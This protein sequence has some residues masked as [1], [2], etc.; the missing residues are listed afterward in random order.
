[1][2][3]YLQIPVVCSREQKVEE[4]QPRADSPDWLQKEMAHTRAGLGSL[5][6]NVVLLPKDQDRSAFY[7]VRPTC[8]SLPAAP[9]H[10]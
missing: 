7:P 6:Q 10:G 2:H 8:T 9:I 5:H 1:M 3:Q 4:L